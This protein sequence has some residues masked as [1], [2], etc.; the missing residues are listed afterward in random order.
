M[1]DP[2]LPRTFIIDYTVYFLNG[3]PEQHT[4][5]IKG[6][7]NE[8]FAKLKL[9]VWLCRKYSDIERMEIQ[10]CREWTVVEELLKGFGMKF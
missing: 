8:L 4:T 2:S 7:T 3:Q 10:K 9:E 1:T 6:C 5:K